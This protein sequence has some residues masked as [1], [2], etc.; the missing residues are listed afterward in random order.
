MSDLSPTQKAEFIE[1]IELLCHEAA[2]EILPHYGPEVEIERKSDA[3]RSHW[4]T[5]TQKNASAS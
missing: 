5:A 1:F 2:L 3:T 4:L